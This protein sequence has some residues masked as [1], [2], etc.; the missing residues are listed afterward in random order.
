V[1]DPTHRIHHRR[2]CWPRD[3]GPSVFVPSPIGSLSEADGSADGD[4]VLA[5]TL[6]DVGA[7]LPSVI[8]TLTIGAGIGPGPGVR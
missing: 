8:G 5:S 1:Y 7:A 4:N 2:G 6:G 3:R